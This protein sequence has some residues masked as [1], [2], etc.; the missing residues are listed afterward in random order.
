MANWANLFRSTVPL[1]GCILLSGC[2][3][4]GQSLVEEERESN[5][6]EGK[7]RI[8]TMDFKGAIESFEKSL[9]VNPKSAAAHFELACLFEKRQNDPAAAIYHY[10]QYLAIRQKAGNAEIVNEHITACKQELARAISL[11]P[12]SEKQQR[13]FEQLSAENKRLR[14]D[15][16]K[17]RSYAN[18]LEAL[19]NQAGA[20]PLA[21][22][23]SGASE[24][25]VG[26]SSQNPPAPVISEVATR[27]GG[28]PSTSTSIRTHIIQA[29]ETPTL[30]ARKYGLKVQ[31][32]MAANPRMD[33]RRLRP[34]QTLALPA[35]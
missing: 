35:P 30:I 2:L 21:G 20:A 10:Q 3:G 27:A 5:F 11:G 23:R 7:S 33:A 18:H 17:W 22:N 4:S 1:L 26:A 9:E 16:D 6:V 31:S 13:E 8:K 19:T 28:S 25:R 24:G 14:Q 29:G 15:V 34:G 32:L 12:V